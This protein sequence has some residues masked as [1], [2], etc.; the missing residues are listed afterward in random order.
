MYIMYIL[1]KKV[2]KNKFFIRLCQLSMFE[3]SY[4][5]SNSYW[6][7]I[8]M[9]ICIAWLNTDYSYCTDYELDKLRQD[10]AYW[11]DDLVGLQ[12][13]YKEKGYDVLKLNQLSQ[14]QVA[15][16]ADLEEAI[17]DGRRNVST[18][19]KDIADLSKRNQQS[20]S[21]PTIG[22]R[23]GESSQSQSNKKQS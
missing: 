1:Y 18:S 22:K 3:I 16:K 5:I 10:L 17:K 12:Q 19:I 23:R 8:I 6:F 21:S 2:M 13:L 15:E 20:Y 4:R 14:E 7:I 9:Y 11:Q